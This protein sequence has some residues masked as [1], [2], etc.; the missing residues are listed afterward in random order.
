MKPPEIIKMGL[1]NVAETF[2]THIFD[3]AN[4]ASPL[5]RASVSWALINLSDALKLSA[6]LGQRCD[7]EA[8]E[9]FRIDEGDLHALICAARVCACHLTTRRIERRWKGLQGVSN[10]T[11]TWV[12]SIGPGGISFEEARASGRDNDVKITFGGVELYVLHNLTA[13]YNWLRDRYC[14]D[15]PRFM[16]TT[17]D[18]G[19]RPGRG[20]DHPVARGDAT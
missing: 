4:V 19:E 12:F 20:E 8:P 1:T 5:Y 7:L 3:G 13:A 11:I 16:A 9:I 18:R 15:L 6:E 17:W 14:P 10:G 2:R